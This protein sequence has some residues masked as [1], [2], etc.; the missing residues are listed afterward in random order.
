MATYVPG[1]ETY[2]PDIKP[3]TPDYKFLSA[4]LDVRQ[5]KY[6][7]NW[8]AT[9]DVYNKVVFADLSRTDTNEQREQYVN[10][11]APSLEK[12]SGMDLSLA[13]NAQSAKA[14]F[15]PFFED[16]LIVKDMVKTAN[17]RKEMSHAQRLLAS[18]DSAVNGQYWRDGVTSLQYRMDDFIGMDAD[19]AIAAPLY[20]Y[21]PKADMFKLSE[22]ILGGMKPPLKIKID[23]F[24][25][26]PDGSAN[27][28]WIVTQ[29]NGE[30][31]VGPALQIIRK[32][33]SS[34][35]R[36]LQ[37]Y[38]TQAYVAGRD[39]AAAGM[40]GGDF[41]T[42]AEGQEAWAQTT[43]GN[44]EANNKSRLA[45]GEKKLIIQK[46]TNVRW[47]NYKKETG[48]IPDSDEDKLMKEQLSAYEAT[49]LAM[50][51]QMEVAK[52]IATPSTDLES[53]LN[54]AYQLLMMTNMDADMVAAAQ[55]YS[56]RDMESTMRVNPYAKQ[57]KQFKMDMAK[58]SANATNRRSLAFDLQA[59][60]KKDDIELAELKGETMTAARAMMNALDA[61]NHSIGGAGTNQFATDEDGNIDPNTDVPVLSEN[62]YADRNNKLQSYKIESI[63]TAL[64]VQNPR[65]NN[66]G[67]GEFTDTWTIK[68]EEGDFTGTLSEIRSKLS[69][70]KEGT[71]GYVHAKGINSIF[72]DHKSIITARDPETGDLIMKSTNPNLVSHPDFVSLVNDMIGIG[73]NQDIADRTYEATLKVYEDASKTT[74]ALV[75]SSDK[76]VDAMMKKGMP[77]LMMDLPSGGQRVMDKDE[78][79][80]AALAKLKAKQMTNHD[81]VWADDTGTSNE[82][83]M[84]WEDVP[85]GSTYTVRT[86]DGN[87]TKQRTEKKW[88]LD[89]RAFRDE[90][91]QVYKALYE[92]LNGGLTGAITEGE[93]G[94]P[95]ATFD[96]MLN[97]KSG[98]LQDLE[99]GVTYQ[100]SF[101]PKVPEG[102][103]AVIMMQYA[104]QMAALNAKGI[105]PTMFTGTYAEGSD[106]SENPK[107][108]QFMNETMQ[109]TRSML[110]NPKSTNSLPG[111]PR[112]TWTYSPVLGD[113]EDGT[114]TTAGYTWTPTEEYVN[115][116][117]KGG[118][119]DANYGGYPFTKAELMKGVT[120]L[121][122]Q[123]EDV[124]PRSI[125][126][127][128]N[129]GSPIVS[130]IMSSPKGVYTN[131]ENNKAGDGIGSYS[132]S[133]ISNNEYV[134]NYQYRT[135]Q[136]SVD[137][138][139]GGYTTSA[140]QP[141]TYRIKGNDFSELN[142]SENAIKEFFRQKA[143]ASDLAKSKD[144]AVNGKK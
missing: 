67:G 30:P 120:I 108:A 118:K 86:M 117:M 44:I 93:K 75:R 126:T 80:A 95:T 99:S 35:G 22:E 11:L 128:T 71:E 43:I 46:E 106:M 121:F 81:Q 72:N 139:G 33:L 92:K 91:A 73:V 142:N 16:K 34:D 129:W 111:S 38:Q 40:Q 114:K 31:V 102:Q 78:Y 100:G 115:S 141:T 52:V 83:Y 143:L 79:Y 131:K 9:N 29:Q 134:M 110:G 68:A 105:T 25:V 21:V 42:V 136:P 133:K 62:Q 54:R 65:G 15:A 127:G 116:K 97:G 113:P 2:L 36:V 119:G 4:V 125:N 101:D 140:W 14:V 130:K 64:R 37:A 51:N 55:S 26:N 12:I 8:Q 59:Q 6:N 90:T 84:H 104:N 123:S 85:V 45:K 124:N 74:E 135:Y 82:D 18:P 28:D 89:E 112:G 61:N 60:K 24:G 66:L 96:G 56:M 27:T 41:T 98:S 7:T 122:D 107:V 13:Q 47:E 109:D 23:H 19:S 57:Q 94:I 103:G 138:K 144:K 17:Y 76:H 69:E 50:E 53:T 20:K 63:L 137:G 77:G 5:D 3:F 88:V 1:S 70:K 87:V 58:I 48:V 39:F 132:Y 32:R 10:N 49:K